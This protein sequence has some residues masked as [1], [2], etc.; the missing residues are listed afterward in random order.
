MSSIQTPPVRPHVF[1]THTAVLFLIL[2][3]SI[4]IGALRAQ[5]TGLDEHA[6]RPVFPVT[7]LQAQDLSEGAG[8]QIA[9][10]WTKASDDASYRILRSTSPDGAYQLVM[11]V[12]KGTEQFVDETVK[13]GTDYYYLV[14]VTEGKR[15]A[16]R[17]AQ[18]ELSFDEGGEKRS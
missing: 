3:F 9:L 5:S 7:H 14:E 18:R 6:P 16:Y 15:T 12:E 1:A 4:G 17:D 10:T 2:L 13:D 11:E 8:G